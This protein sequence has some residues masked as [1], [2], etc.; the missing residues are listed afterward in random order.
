MDH[1]VS[2]GRTKAGVP[3]TV[4]HSNE[5]GLRKLHGYAQTAFANER[6]VVHDITRTSYGIPKVQGPRGEE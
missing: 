5:A 1:S 4:E 2:L 3:V 6:S